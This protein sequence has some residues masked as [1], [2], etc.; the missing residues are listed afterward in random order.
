MVNDIVE[1][2][3]RRAKEID[4]ILEINEITFQK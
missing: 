1:T 2:S 4:P 3:T